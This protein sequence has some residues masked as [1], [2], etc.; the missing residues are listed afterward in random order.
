LQT[1][2]LYSIQI[3]KN[4][5]LKHSVFTSSIRHHQL[6]F[7]IFSTLNTLNIIHNKLRIMAFSKFNSNVCKL[8][9][10]TQILTIDR[11]FKLEI[12]KL[13]YK[14]KFRLAPKQFTELFTK[15]E[16]IHSYHK[17]NDQVLIMPFLGLD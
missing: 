11:I 7:I 17:N 15:I 8:Y 1:R 3:L 16:D 9:K 13:M 14:I 10:D 12:S 5:V 6:G 2:A 4:S